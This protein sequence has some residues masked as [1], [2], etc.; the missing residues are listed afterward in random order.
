[1]YGHCIKLN[2]TITFLKE[3]DSRYLENRS[4]SQN[5][6]TS[7]SEYLRVLGHKAGTR[8]VLCFRYGGGSLGAPV[9]LSVLSYCKYKCI[10]NEDVSPVTHHT[11]PSV[12]FWEPDRGEDG[13]SRG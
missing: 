7:G 13:G 3:T 12:A 10:T 9:A 6:D 8:C 5:E 1:M 11:W 4:R 2:R